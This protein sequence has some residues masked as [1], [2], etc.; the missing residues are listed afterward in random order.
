MS[1]SFTLLFF[2]FIIS[3]LLLVV[4]RIRPLSII[5]GLP[6]A[7]IAFIGLQSVVFNF[8][9]IWN[10]VTV[11][12]VVGSNSILSL[13]A[14]VWLFL[15]CRESPRKH[16]EIKIRA[17]VRAFQN[18]IFYLLAPLLIIF[19]HIGF[20][21]SVPNT[22]DSLTYHMARV[23]HWIQNQSIAYYPTNISRQNEMSPGAE[24]VIFFLQLLAGNDRLAV[25]PQFVSYIF[26]AFGLVYLLRV[27][28]IPKKSVPALV[29]LS[30]STPM[31]VLQAT[32][33]QNDLVCSL[34]VLAIL[35]SLSRLLRGKVK[36]LRTSE[37]VLICLSISVGYLVKPTSLLFAF[38]FI[39]A[40]IIIQ[41]RNLPQLNILQGQ[42]IGRLIV[43]I[44][45]ALLVAGPD[46]IRK[47]IHNVERKEVY[48][49][50]AQWDTDRLL[51]PIRTLGQ[52][53]PWPEVTKDILG[54]FGYKGSIITS[55]VF[56]IT[57]DFIG[58]PVQLL[59][60]LA[61][62]SITL[63]I[64]FFGLV[65]KNKRGSYLLLSLC[66]L[67]AWCCFALFV[68]NQLWI[69]RLQLPSFFLVPIS[70]A[71]LLELIKRNKM[72]FTLVNGLVI[73]VTLFSLSYATYAAVH[74]KTRSLDLAMFWG[75]RVLPR[76]NGYY[77]NV[78]IKERHDF[79]IK[80]TIEQKCD[81]IGL[82]L[83][84]DSVDY[85]LTWQLMNLGKNARHVFPGGVDAWPCMMYVEDGGREHV[86][87]QSEQWLS[88]GD[89]HTWLRNEKYEFDRAT[90]ICVKSDPV[91]NNDIILLQDIEFTSNE[92][93]VSLQALGKDSFIELP[94]FS[95]RASSSIVL[96]IKMWSPVETEAQVYYSSEVKG[97][98]LERH[99]Q[100]KKVTSGFNELYFMFP[101]NNMI[102]SIRFD[103]GKL[104]AEYVLYSFEARSVQ[105]KH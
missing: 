81:R 68:R 62:T 74:N 19:Y 30:M 64:S 51:N 87:S 71:Y 65:S 22:Y 25:L 93:G 33:T 45:T 42:Y 5:G 76:E 2:F 53:L 60:L 36:R 56:E 10:K 39:C 88:A 34:T 94:A 24:Y 77:N 79:F 72:L 102:G 32:T 104:A 40:A 92:K 21:T 59:S 73:I 38:P 89:Y 86:P 55:N 96:R 48:P 100:I 91:K 3:V 75:G 95:C 28:R 7:F 23:A 27:Y 82:L 98:F 4:Q 31:A 70:F 16:F 47:I 99:S 46:L 29:L 41:F 101:S 37:Y 14:L 52:N 67:A 35:I 54:W 18:P 9:S 50:L 11:A 12:G 6:I 84:G 90:N 20:L 85:P 26:L 1:T 69:T 103:P 17:L 97:R 105:D 15:S 44:G 61:M 66:P 63:F 78:P 58:N 43:I 83:G 57:Q 8:L 80:K 49:L 13:L